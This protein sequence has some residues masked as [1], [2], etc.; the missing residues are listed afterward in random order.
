MP[1]F[2]LRLVRPVTSVLLHVSSESAASSPGLPITSAS[3]LPFHDHYSVHNS[4]PFHLL[5][6][7]ELEMR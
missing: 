5:L 2:K 7:Y 3:L 1:L 6:L 4:A